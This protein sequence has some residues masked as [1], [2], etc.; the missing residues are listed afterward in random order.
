MPNSN[1][2][3][4]KNKAIADGVFATLFAVGRAVK[5]SEEYAGELYTAVSIGEGIGAVAVASVGFSGGIELCFKGIVPESFTLTEIRESGEE[6][7]LKGL[8]VIN[9]KIVIMAKKS[10]IY[11]VEF[12]I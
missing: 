1:L 3:N 6:N 10:S 2:E 4:R 5:V 8:P 9:G 12:D 11:L 7:S